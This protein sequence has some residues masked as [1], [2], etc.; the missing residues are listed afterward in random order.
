MG[1]KNAF[2]GPKFY[3]VRQLQNNWYYH[4]WATKRQLVFVDTVARR[5]IGKPPGLIWPKINFLETSTKFAAAT[6][7]KHQKENFSVL[8]ALH[9][10]PLGGRRGPFFAPKSAKSAKFLLTT[11]PGRGEN[12]ARIKKCQFLMAEKSISS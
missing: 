7:T 6:I 10:G 2:F 11:L 1:P 3:S 4:D 8:T 5:A 9:G 12:M